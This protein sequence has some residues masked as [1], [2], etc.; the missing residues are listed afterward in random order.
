MKDYS[1]VTTER[2]NNSSRITSENEAWLLNITVIAL[3]AL[4]EDIAE[5]AKHYGVD[6][7]AVKL[8]SQPKNKA[9]IVE[10][11]LGSSNA[12][13]IRAAQWLD[14]GELSRAAAEALAAQ[15]LLTRLLGGSLGLELSKGVARKLQAEIAAR[16]PRNQHRAQVA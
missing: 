1:E 4:P 13:A 14:T 11:V 3:G 9:E 6:L 2:E 8:W 7:N 15:M 16:K 10:Q 5:L 12:L